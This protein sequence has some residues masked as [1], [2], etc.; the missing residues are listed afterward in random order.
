MLLVPFLGDG[1]TMV[2]KLSNLF[3]TQG[4]VLFSQSKKVYIFVVFHISL[5][6]CVSSVPST[7]LSQPSVCAEGTVGLNFMRRTRLV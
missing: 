3:R 7:S 4:G 2:V 5:M 6:D 1:Q